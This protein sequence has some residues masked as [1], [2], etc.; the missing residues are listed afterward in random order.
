MCHWTNGSLFSCPKVINAYCFVG[1]KICKL[2]KSNARGFYSFQ[3]LTPLTCKKSN[4]IITILHIQRYGPPLLVWKKCNRFEKLLRAKDLSDSPRRHFVFFNTT[5]ILG[6]N[7]VNVS[8]KYPF[9]YLLARKKYK[10]DSINTD[11]TRHLYW[12]NG[13]ILRSHNYFCTNL[14]KKQISILPSLA[15]LTIL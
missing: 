1:I 6:C 2:K 11:T 7:V 8:Q 15:D 4:F 13:L 9:F 12:K 14:D 10:K 5:R 3:A